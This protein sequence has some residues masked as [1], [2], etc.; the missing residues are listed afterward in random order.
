[1]ACFPEDVFGPC[2]SACEEWFRDVESE[3]LKEWE[4]ALVCGLRSPEPLPENCS[5]LGCEGVY[6]NYDFCIGACWHF[7]GDAP[8]QLISRAGECR[9]V[10]SCYGHDFEVICPSD[11]DAQ[12]CACLVDNEIVSNCAASPNPVPPDCGETIG[13]FGTCCRDAFAAVLFP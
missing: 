8:E 1:V 13:T 12:S 10:G 5:V 6:K 11:A 7:V 2:V 9:W 3:C 4:A